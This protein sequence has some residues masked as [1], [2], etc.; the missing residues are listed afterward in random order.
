MQIHEFLS[1]ISLSDIVA[2]NE[3]QEVAQRQ[4]ERHDQRR[5]GGRMPRSEK[6]EVSAI[7]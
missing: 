7:E 6:I 1:S 2:R 4:N 5:L 3:V